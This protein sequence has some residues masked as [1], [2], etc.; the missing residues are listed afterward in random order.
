MDYRGAHKRL[1]NLAAPRRFTEKIQWR[2]LFDHNPYFTVLCDKLAVRDFIA[3]RAGPEFL[4]PL[5]WSGQPEAIP[6]DALEPP[7]VLKSTHASGQI[8]MVLGGEP[9][10][11]E[12]IRAKAAAWLKSCYGTSHNEPGYINVPRRLMIERTLTTATGATPEEIRVFVFD[13]K[14]AILN[15]VLVEAGKIRN[16]AFHTPDWRR[17]DWHITRWLDRPFPPPER[18]H[19]ILRTA[20]KL[21]AGFD[22][23]R[24]DFY[25]CGT[26]IHIGEITLYAWS[27]LAR[28][29]PDEADFL[30]GNHWKIPNPLRRATKALFHG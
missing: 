16:G 22:H 8:I 26:K 21:G 19:D 1:P 3:G 20:E 23:I 2:K 4:I 25:N 10:D 5:L 7:Y 27:G 11:R 30:L 29:T 24:V 6:F 12:Q 14:A 28:F 18:L 13:G 17:L 9:I 15:T